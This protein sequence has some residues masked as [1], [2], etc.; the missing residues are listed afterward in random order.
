MGWMENYRSHA[1]WDAVDRTKG[2]LGELQDAG[3]LVGDPDHTEM[4][5]ALLARL[6]GMRD[7]PDITISQTSLSQVT[8]YVEFIHGSLPN[9]T[10]AFTG[11]Y[12]GYSFDSNAQIV[13]AW[14]QPWPA[15]IKNLTS[16]IATVQSG[17]T[18]ARENLATLDEKFATTDTA[19]VDYEAQ[20]RAAAEQLVARVQDQVIEVA[21]G[22]E[23]LS[24]TAETQ[25]GRIDEAIAGFQTKFTAGEDARKEAWAKQ[26]NSQQDEA[27]AHTQ[28]MEEHEAKSV[29]VLQAV[30]ANST[31]TDFGTYANEQNK[32]ATTWRSI[33]AA[34]FGVAGVWFIASSFPWY[35]EGATGWEAALAR[36][37]VTAAVAGVGAYAARESSQH[38]REE[39]R[40]KQVQLAL[41]ALEPFIANLPDTEQKDIRAAAAQAIFVLRPEEPS[42]EVAG[43]DYIELIK[44]LVDKVPTRSP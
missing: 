17:L 25:K 32:A 24:T 36:L 19:I 9:T 1:I 4:L 23:A 21:R 6:D 22:V 2:R 18:A 5:E 30:G 39:R 28:R 20:Q 13:G 35:G 37:G 26:L 41:T 27:E 7:N 31:A 42:N 40:A 33:A 10:S 15:K 43:G 12:S 34:V 14:P 29:K 38:R 3:E 8:Q 11:N 16:Q 44:S